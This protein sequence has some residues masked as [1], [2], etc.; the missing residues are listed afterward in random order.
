M[1]ARMVL[2]AVT[3]ALTLVVSGRTA[4]ANENRNFVAP[5]AAGDEV[6]TPA[7]ESDAAG[8][9]KFQLSAE[10]DALSFKLIVA[11]IDNVLFAH[12]H[13]GA[14]GVNGPVVVFLYDGPTVTTNGVLSEGTVNA[15]DIIPRPDSAACPGGISNFDDL[16]AKMESG[17]AYTNVHTTAFQAGEIRGQ[18][19]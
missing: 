15:S 13:C 17:G 8:L 1:N 12:I 18:I 9:A 3:A 6:Q 19:R 2:I 14:E 5:L 11:N 10:G 7:V 4:G 16:I